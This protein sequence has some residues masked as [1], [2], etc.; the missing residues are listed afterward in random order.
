[1][2][3]AM[4]DTYHKRTVGQRT[5]SPVTQMMGF[6]YDPH[7]SEG[8]LKP[9]I[10]LTSTFVF[11]TAQDGKNFFDYTSGRK[12]LPEGARESQHVLGVAG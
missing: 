7:L 9:P 11:R 8:A 3:L 4:T 5:L 2:F 10:F 1:M 12:Q 6:G